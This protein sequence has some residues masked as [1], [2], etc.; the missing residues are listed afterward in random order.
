MQ[1]KCWR[2]GS[3]ETTNINY[4][5]T[6]WDVICAE[7]GADSLEVDAYIKAIKS[8]NNFC[9]ESLENACKICPE[10]T[11]PFECD[12]IF[13]KKENKFGIIYRDGTDSFIEI[14]FCPFCGFNL[15]FKKEN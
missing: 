14:N 2:C 4:S 5:N 3:V 11:S 9:C 6:D 12:T 7:C 15:S 8:K 10:H 13:Y 1:N